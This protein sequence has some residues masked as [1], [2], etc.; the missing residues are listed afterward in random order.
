MPTDDPA[1]YASAARARIAAQGFR[2]LRMRSVAQE[3]GASLGSLNHHVGDKAALIAAIVREERRERQLQHALWRRR[4]ACLDLTDATVLAAAIATYLDEAALVHRAMALT[5]CELLVEAVMAPQEFPGIDLLLADEE[6]LWVDLLA[7]GYGSDAD[8]FGRAIVGYCHDERPFTIALAGHADYR[9]LRS[10]TIASVSAG[11]AGRGDGLAAR[12]GDLVA[13]CGSDPAVSPLPVDLPD[14]SKKAV[15]AQHIA[16][17]IAEQGV[18]AV[19]HRAVAA[20]AGVSNSRIAHHFRTQADLLDAGFGAL[21][22]AMRQE[23]R[24]LDLPEPERHRG[25]AMIRATHSIALVA[26]RDPAL[27]PFALDMRRRRS[28]NVR[29]RLRGMLGG[30]RAADDATLQAVSMM[31]IGSGF[32]AMASGGADG[33]SAITVEQLAGLRR[34]FLAARSG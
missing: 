15:L 27:Q 18:S 4:V 1:K 17:V 32:A 28:E 21:I 12:F 6:R 33:R 24:S 23:M 16:Q 25:M 19:T 29:E 5:G 7:T 11:L 3:A 2:G 20:R 10:A 22:L 14:G 34:R 31:T 26:A 30:D 8:L 9:L 13:A